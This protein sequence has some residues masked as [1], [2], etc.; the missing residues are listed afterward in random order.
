[1][2]VTI[3]ATQ[4]DDWQT[5][6]DELEAWHAVSCTAVSLREVCE[7][8]SGELADATGRPLAHASVLARSEGVRV[9]DLRPIIDP[10]SDPI[11]E[12]TVLEN[13][14]PDAVP[15]EWSRSR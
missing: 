14:V 15:E 2:H 6:A 9:L 12:L 3:T 10:A 8:G 4:G 1:M 5:A 7:A 11:A 13:P